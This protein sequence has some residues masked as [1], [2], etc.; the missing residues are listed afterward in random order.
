MIGL[1]QHQSTPLQIAAMAFLTLVLG[2]VRTLAIVYSPMERKMM[3]HL[4]I[5]TR[6]PVKETQ[7]DRK[8]PIPGSTQSLSVQ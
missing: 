4:D 3:K 2:A 7:S 1:Y 5:T 6:G 8:D